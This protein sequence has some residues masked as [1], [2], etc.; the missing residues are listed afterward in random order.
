MFSVLSMTRQPDD[1]LIKEI[2]EK[3]KQ[4]QNIAEGAYRVRRGCFWGNPVPYVHDSI[5][6]TEAPDNRGA[7]NGFRLAHSARF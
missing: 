3:Q 2:K 5:R 7:G 6:F 1:P 4:P